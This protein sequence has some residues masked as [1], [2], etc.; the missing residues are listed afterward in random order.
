MKQKRFERDSRV[1]SLVNDV[2]LQQGGR[3]AIQNYS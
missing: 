1:N 3:H 2:V